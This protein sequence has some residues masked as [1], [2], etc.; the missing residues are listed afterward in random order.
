MMLAV[1]KNTRML[2]YENKYSVNPDGYPQQNTLC[3]RLIARV[4]KFLSVGTR[5][6]KS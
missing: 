4:K 1:I 2:L 3:P 6:S 5:P